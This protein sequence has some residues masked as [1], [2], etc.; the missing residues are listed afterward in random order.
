MCSGCEYDIH[1]TP[2][3]PPH[4]TLRCSISVS[5]PA[6]N[7]LARYGLYTPYSHHTSDLFTHPE[8]ARQSVQG[9]QSA[10]LV[11]YEDGGA[12]RPRYSQFWVRALPSGTSIA[13]GRARAASSWLRRATDVL[14]APSVRMAQ[15]GKHVTRTLAEACQGLRLSNHC[16]YRSKH[17]NR[18]VDCAEQET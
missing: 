18:S 14:P 13:N 3:R 2:R 6:R 8:S 15:G 5:I 4:T 10:R 17:T 7:I 16:R 12:A 1:T 11:L 9:T